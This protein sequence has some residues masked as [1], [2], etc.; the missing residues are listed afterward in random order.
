MSSSEPIGK[1]SILRNSGSFSFSRSY[2]K[3]YSRR[4]PSLSKVMPRHSTGPPV[5]RVG[6]SGEYPSS[7]CMRCPAKS[8]LLFKTV[9]PPIL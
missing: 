5:P 7:S 1:P 6:R 4:A 3:R 9:S 8:I 2:S